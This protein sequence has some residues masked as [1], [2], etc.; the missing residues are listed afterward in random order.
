MNFLQKKSKLP[1]DSERFVWYHLCVRNKGWKMSE[2]YKALKGKLE[3][4]V[5]LKNQLEEEYAKYKNIDTSLASNRYCEAYKKLYTDGRLETKPKNDKEKLQ[6]KVNLA[7]NDVAFLQARIRVCKDKLEKIS[8]RKSSAEKTK[9][10][11]NS[12]KQ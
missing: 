4:L 3:E 12:K 8:Q 2:S 10:M 1:L 5:A 6:R 11:T 7:S 9:T